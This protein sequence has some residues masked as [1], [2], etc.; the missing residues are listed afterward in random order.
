MKVLLSTTEPPNYYKNLVD[1]G[2][3]KLLS[4]LYKIPRKFKLETLLVELKKEDFF[5]NKEEYLFYIELDSLED[6]RE[7]QKSIKEEFVF[8]GNTLLSSK[9]KDKI[10]KAPVEIEIYNHYRE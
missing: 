3:I 2:D 9:F 6:L 7:L 8:K 5:K 1:K 4:D 10:P